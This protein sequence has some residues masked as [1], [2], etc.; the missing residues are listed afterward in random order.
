MPL[1]TV[2]D[3]F[4][5]TIPAKLRSQIAIEVGDVLEATVEEGAIVLRPKLVID[6]TSVADEVARLLAGVPIW[7]EDQGR[8]ED[9]VIDEAIAEVKAARED[10]KR[11]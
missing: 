7:P 5:V 2:K 11:R 10:R 8:S 6:R 1:L 9:D 4:Q 3:K